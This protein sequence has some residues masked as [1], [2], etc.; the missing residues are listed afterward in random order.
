[1][2]KI[3]GEKNQFLN[4]INFNSATELTKRNNCITYGMLETIQPTLTLPGLCMGNS[5][6]APTGGHAPTTDHIKTYLHHIV[7]STYYITCFFF[8]TPVIIFLFILCI[9]SL[10]MDLKHQWE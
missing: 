1:M 2:N 5:L 8:I 6:V 7:Y 4:T 9:E 3:Q 10:N